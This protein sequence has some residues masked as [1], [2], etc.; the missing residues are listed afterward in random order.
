MAGK[1]RI[2]KDAL[3]DLVAIRE[4]GRQ[5][6]ER[7]HD[8]LNS[9]HPLPLRREALQENVANCLDGDFS[10]AE[11]LV[12]QLLAFYQ[13][14]KQRELD[15]EKDLLDGLREGLNN[16]SPNWSDE[17]LLR[18]KA[19]EPSLGLLVT[20]NAVRTVSKATLLE[21][22]FANLFKSGRIVTDIRPVFNDLDGDDMAI[23]G[24]VVSHTFRLSYDNS[25][26]DH[27]LSLAMDK[28]DILALMQQCERA[29]QK[30]Q[31]AKA[32]VSRNDF[33]AVICGEEPDA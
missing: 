6:L 17:E 27:D 2:P 31:R 26:G 11:R 15:S 30:A 14:V 16:I 22:D 20:S 8:S 13:L 21:Y 9:I 1:I 4:I 19:I 25:D 28:K 5:S 3:P 18:W 12:R 33:P 23:D 29:L 24:A 10:L 32:L 7:V